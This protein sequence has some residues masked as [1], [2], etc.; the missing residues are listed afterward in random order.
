MTFARTKRRW[1]GKVVAVFGVSLSLGLSAC[2]SPSGT[3][4]TTSST[5]S[6]STSTTM[7]P[8]VTS[9]DLKSMLLRLKALPK[10]WYEPPA[11][12]QRQQ[13]LVD[14]PGCPAITSLNNFPSAYVTYYNRSGFAGFTE[15]LWAVPPTT[16]ATLTTRIF[17]EMGNPS[18]SL[19]SDYIIDLLA[20]KVGDQVAHWTVLNGGIE[21][22]WAR[23]GSVIASISYD[24]GLANDPELGVLLKHAAARID[25]GLPSR[26]A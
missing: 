22:V 9:A 14:T 24:T 1:T 10:G 17:K 20:P 4:G 26:P 7:P 2:S 19:G 18:C 15:A 3:S 8:T 12:I 11:E 6:T 13:Q 5:S 16:A 25:D 21:L 23:F